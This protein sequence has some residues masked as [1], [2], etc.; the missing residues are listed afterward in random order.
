MKPLAVLYLFFLFYRKTLLGESVKVRFPFKQTILL[1]I[2]GEK[3]SGG[4][5]GLFYEG[6]INN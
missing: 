6:S 1:K 2:N 5:T 4:A 3:T